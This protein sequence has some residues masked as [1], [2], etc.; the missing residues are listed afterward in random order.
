MKQNK[1]DK[2]LV[3][4]LRKIERVL[5]SLA[6]EVSRLAEEYEFPLIKAELD[7]LKSKGRKTNISTAFL[8][9]KYGI[10][11]GSASRLRDRLLLSGKK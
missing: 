7:Q 1:T 4:H 10:G 2:R 11:Y 8:Q 5:G 3:L 6:Q 9:R